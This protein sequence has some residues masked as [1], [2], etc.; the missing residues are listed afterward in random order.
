MV[1]WS[2]T[3]EVS[4]SDEILNQI[5]TKVSSVG[6]ETTQ[7]KRWKLSIGRLFDLNDQIAMHTFINSVFS[8]G[9]HSG[10]VCFEVSGCGLP[11]KRIVELVASKVSG[12]ARMFGSTNYGDDFYWYFKRDLAE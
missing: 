2:A 8:E 5:K 12:N 3:F 9:T 7:D 11:N 1:Y 10:S 6:V 4:A